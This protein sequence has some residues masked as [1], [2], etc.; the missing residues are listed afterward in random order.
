MARA[1]TFFVGLRDQTADL[2]TSG[3]SVD[4]LGQPGSGR[5]TLVA[6]V[7]SALVELGW[8]VVHVRGVAALADRPLEALAVADLLRRPAQRPESRVAATVERLRSELAD[9]RTVLVV[10]DADDLDVT[11]AGAIAA[12][13]GQRPFPVLTTSRPRPAYRQAPVT[14]RSSIRPGVVLDI[15]PLDFVEVLAILA[16]ILPGDIEPDT[17]ARIHALSGGLP[18][19]IVAVAV[20]ARQTGRIRQIDGVWVADA[21][22]WT[23]GL[24][25]V[26]QTLIADLGEPALEALQMLSLAGTVPVSLAAELVGWAALEELD[27][28]GLLRFVPR[29]DDVVL[30]IF[31]PL[32][33]ERYRRPPLGARSLHFNARIAALLD[34]STT[35]MPGA[36]TLL[37]PAVTAPWFWPGD[38]QPTAPRFDRDEGNVEAAELSDTVHV[39]LMR[40][41]W[42][43]Q[44]LLRRREWERNPE[45]ATAILYLRA[46]LVNN[47]EVETMSRVVAQTPP[48]TDQAQMAELHRWHALVLAYA[49]DDLAGARTLLQRA[50]TEVGPWAEVLHAVEDYLTLTLDR[51]PEPR[52][53]AVQ[54]TET[55]QFSAAVS[56]ATHIA[57][58]DVSEARTALEAAEWT[59]ADMIRTRDVVRG[60]ANLI[61]G[62]VE[63]A[64]AWSRRHVEEARD[65]LDTESVYGHAYVAVSALILSGR[66][67]ELRTMLGNVLS[68][69][70]TSSV[71]RHYVDSLLGLAAVLAA[72]DGHT[73]RD[74][75]YYRYLRSAARSSTLPLPAWAMARADIEVAD[76][77]PEGAEHLWDAVQGYLD[78]G[79]VVSA[80]LLGG[81]ALDL[82]P[83]PDR[84]ATLREATGPRAAGLL[85]AVLRVAEAAVDDDPVAGARLGRRLIDAGL[86]SLGVRATGHSIRR[87]RASGAATESREVLDALVRQLHGAGIDPDPLLGSLAPTRQLSPREQQVGSL[88]AH[89]MT[90][91]EIA[92][93]L[94]ITPKTVENHLS[95]ILRKLGATDRSEVV[96]VFR[97]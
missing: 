65:A 62:E 72:R 17:L 54:R 19:L 79:L 53:V 76:D 75:S 16:D 23:P 88:V 82:S 71:Q 85:D 51:L 80:V 56:A 8:D 67:N 95:R 30:G 10:D 31:P 70:L 57:V 3:V 78:R 61:A 84:V 6:S 77:D 7:T 73:T 1:N 37:P 97:G 4:V 25:R 49:A 64:L 74:A 45:A 52:A 83:D 35:A 93:M 14:L 48:S 2:L 36:S 40:E 11:S 60:M 81:V 86:V 44:L 24:T 22:L 50:A 68:T 46:L 55:R 58:G 20:A 15:P 29:G 5:T 34:P 18:N 89:G 66:M 27:A 59:D 12:A 42:H 92:R 13:H 28:C 69:G 94:G 43:R 39:R 63:E 87:L 9:G 26:V 33:E 90:N 41:H 47:A 21:D 96:G 38:A 32:V 91:A